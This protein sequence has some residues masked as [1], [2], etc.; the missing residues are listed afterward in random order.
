M[1]RL[2]L[3]NAVHSGHS[4]DVHLGVP[5]TVKQHHRVRREQVHSL[6]A[7][8]CAE[9]EHIVGTVG[10]VELVDQYFAHHTVGGPVQAAVAVTAPVQKVAD[11]VETLGEL[12]EDHHSVALVGQ[13]GQQSVQYD[14]LA[15]SCDDLF[16]YLAVLGTRSREQVRVIGGLAQLRQQGLQP[17]PLARLASWILRVHFSIF[18]ILEAHDGTA[19]SQQQSL[20]PE[21][22]HLRQRTSDECL[23][24]GRQGLLYLS[25]HS[26]QQERAQHVVGSVQCF[27]VNVH[28]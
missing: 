25:L 22:L 3:S 4:L 23:E 13:F 27:A 10:L 28:L 7:G 26:A 18:F 24:L 19:L 21:T 2:G 12:A 8:A 14:H 9:T 6:S 20:D 17:L 16:S 11:N 5:I 1:H 15:R